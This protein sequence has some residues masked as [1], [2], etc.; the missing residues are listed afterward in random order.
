MRGIIQ[1]EEAQ[2]MPSEVLQPDYSNSVDMPLAMVMGEDLV[3]VV[4]WFAHEWSVRNAS[5][6]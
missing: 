6:T 4:E 5:S 1:H 2:L 3:K